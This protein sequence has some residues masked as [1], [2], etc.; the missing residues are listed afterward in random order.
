MKAQVHTGCHCPIDFA[1]AHCQYLK[2][3]IDEESLV[4]EGLI[5]EVGENFF[6]FVPQKRDHSTA[7]GI[8]IGI[9]VSVLVAVG[10]AI[11]KG[12]KKEQR[13]SFSQLQQF[14]HS[15]GPSMDSMDDDLK[16]EE[17]CSLNDSNKK[18]HKSGTSKIEII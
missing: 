10:V 2:A 12:M 11:S 1:G 18:V 9:G 3:T 4:G 5:E 15:P 13:I 8:A 14:I 7:T 16:M 6:G 17:S